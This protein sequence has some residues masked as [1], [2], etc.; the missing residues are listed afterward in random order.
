M[1]QPMHAAFGM[2]DRQ[3][4][5]DVGSG[6]GH[7]DVVASGREELEEGCQARSSPGGGDVLGASGMGIHSKGRDT[8]T[9]GTGHSH[10]HA[11]VHLSMSRGRPTHTQ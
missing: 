8:R 7:G 11:C 10:P 1:L 9:L 5:G 3:R 6:R 4:T 2:H